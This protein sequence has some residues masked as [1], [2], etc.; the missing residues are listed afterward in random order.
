MGCV[1]WRSIDKKA[2]EA[3][4]MKFTVLAVSTR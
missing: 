2:A 4:K 3:K 1:V